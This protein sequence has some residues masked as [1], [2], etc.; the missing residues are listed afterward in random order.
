[1]TDFRSPLHQAVSE[2]DPNALRT[3][4]LR[5]EFVL[6]STEVGDQEDGGEVGAVTAELEDMEVLLAF[7]SEQAAGQFVRDS[8]DLFEEDEEVDGIVM[9]G[10]TLLEQLPQGFGILL[11]AES[12]DAL[13]I[14]PGL[15]ADIEGD[16]E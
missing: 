2:N 3:L 1:M 15:L 4:L 14:E 11:D 12:D 9:D 5:G 6:L 8:G 13:V 7:S 16:S 10:S